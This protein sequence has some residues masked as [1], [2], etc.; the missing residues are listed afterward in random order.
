MKPLVRES[1]PEDKLR[2]RIYQSC[3]LVQKNC[4]NLE[5]ENKWFEKRIRNMQEDS[6]KVMTRIM[7]FINHGQ[8]ADNYMQVKTMSQKNVQ[9]VRESHDRFA[10]ETNLK[11]ELMKRESK[12]RIQERTTEIRLSK[13]QLIN[14]EREFKQKYFQQ[15]E[16]RQRELMNKSKRNFAAKSLNMKEVKEKVVQE[17]VEAYTKE[18]MAFFENEKSV[19]DQRLE[20]NR[21]LRSVYQEQQEVI[22]KQTQ[23]KKSLMLYRDL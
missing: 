23:L 15:K 11:S 2:N 10:K 9:A 4:K 17:K 18:K 12:R 19:L 8:K 5:K 14:E 13:V 22:R 7:L 20:E 16:E 6:S 1:S 21:L 3:S